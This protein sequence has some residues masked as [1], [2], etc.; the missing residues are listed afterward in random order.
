MPRD[1]HPIPLRAK[2]LGAYAT[3]IANTLKALFMLLFQLI[4]T[5]SKA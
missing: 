4:F 5:A 1:I 2:I 3:P